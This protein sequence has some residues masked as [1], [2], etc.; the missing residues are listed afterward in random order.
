[1]GKEIIIIAQKIKEI[2]LIPKLSSEFSCQ[3]CTLF[4]MLD[5]N[6][7]P[8]SL[9]HFSVQKNFGML[10]LDPFKSATFAQ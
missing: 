6:S 10:S 9:Q 3:F 7:S 5:T 8:P 4:V 1:L 2:T